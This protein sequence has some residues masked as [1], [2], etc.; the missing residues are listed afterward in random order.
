MWTDENVDYNLTV[1]PEFAVDQSRMSLD[2]TLGKLVFEEG[3]LLKGQSYSIRLEVRNHT[4]SRFGKLFERYTVKYY[5]FTTVSPP[6]GG[7][8]FVSPGECGFEF[9]TDITMTIR[10]W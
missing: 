8:F 6:T 10:G 5:N 7:E 1:T 3:A 4:Y 2:K 9:E